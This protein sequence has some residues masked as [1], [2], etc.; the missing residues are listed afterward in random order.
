MIEPQVSR[1]LMRGYGVAD[2][3]EG[4]LP[5]SWAGERLQQAHSYWICSSRPD[6][7]PHV[8]PVWGLRLDGAFW[9]S[10]GRGS[11]KARNLLANPAVVVHLESGD[12]TVI[13][14]GAVRQ[15]S[16][17][18][19]LQPYVDAYDAKYGHRPDPSDPDQLTFALRPRT[20]YAWTE[21][22]FQRTP[23]RWRF[24]A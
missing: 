7:R 5:W 14:E 2:T 4:M 20:A 8:A 15:L 21:R 13:L 17:S 22:D 1:P 9:F 18:A 11:R 12:E 6:G 24:P 19:G 16:D 3:P 10:T 23:A